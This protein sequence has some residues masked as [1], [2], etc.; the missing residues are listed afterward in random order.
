MCSLYSL[1][2]GIKMLMLWTVIF[3]FVIKL[4]FITACIEM[5]VAVLLVGFILLFVILY[6]GAIVFTVRFFFLKVLSSEN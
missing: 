6:F 3:I 4:L 2:E 5:L 1:E